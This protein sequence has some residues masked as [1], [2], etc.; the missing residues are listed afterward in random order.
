MRHILLVFICVMALTMPAVTLAMN[1]IYQEENTQPDE[2]SGEVIKEIQD[3]IDSLVG[4]TDFTEWQET[5]EN[6]GLEL[7]KIC[8]GDNVRD[9][10]LAV[11]YGEARIDADS[12]F[13][14]FTDSLKKR[15][16]EKIGLVVALLGVGLL[17][18]LADLLISGGEK[19]SIREVSSF[20]CQGVA[21]G[22]VV[23]TLSNMASTTKNGISGAVD[24]IEVSNPTLAVMLTAS[25][26]SMVSGAISPLMTFL[27]STVAKLL[28][29]IV[30]PLALSGGV[31]AIVNNLSGRKQVGE[32]QSLAKEAS[33][34]T[35]G[36]IFTLYIGI[37]AITGLSISSTNGLSLRTAKFAVEKFVPIIGGAASGTID[38]VLFCA[39]LVKNAAGVTAIIVSIGYAAVPLIELLGTMIVL[40]ASAAL[41]EPIADSRI[42]SML[43]E[44][45]ESSKYLFA[46]M[47][48]IILMFI[49][50]VGIIVGTGNI[51]I[52]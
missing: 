36:L 52:A 2:G 5:L 15:V 49:I 18:G 8:N 16:T 17:S 10:V 12:V 47:F 30:L 25:G 46:A 35:V 26:S 23:Y 42:V 51:Y 37:T 38:T 19:N 22:I 21:V 29:T 14:L 32:L 9:L 31:L 41:C 33:K 45:A 50:T 48:G 27:T 13:S 28:Q 39:Q 6:N 43:K 20:L 4:E 34:W 11:A 7:A 1:P 44:V 40:R 24:F 3:E